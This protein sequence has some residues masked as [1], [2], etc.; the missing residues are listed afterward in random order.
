MFPVRLLRRLTAAFAGASL[1]LVAGAATAEPCCKTRNLITVIIDGARWEEVFRGIDPRFIDPSASAYYR[2][3]AQAETFKA[4]LWRETPQERREALAPFLWTTVAA[5][6][7]L[8][9]NHDKGSQVRLRNGFHISYPGHSEFLTGIADDE[10]IVSNAFKPNPNKTILEALDARLAFSGRVAAFSTWDAYP[11]ILDV[12]RSGLP[13][14][15]PATPTPVSDPEGR[16]DVLKGLL[17]DTGPSLHSDAITF[18]L[19]L[20]YLKL[21]RP[22]VLHLSFQ[23]ADR[24]AHA[25]HYDDYAYAI[26]SADA[27]LRQIWEWVQSDP[28]YRDQTT[29]IVATDHGRGAASLELFKTHGTPGYRRVAPGEVNPTDGDQYSWIAILGPD[30]PA[31]GEISG[32][33]P[34][35]IAQVAATAMALLREPYVG[36][37]PTLRPAPPIP[38][39]LPTGGWKSN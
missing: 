35:E 3:P 9:G 36:D 1:A 31:G 21:K 2:L 4:A 20:E 14:H 29:L 38:T 7:Q 30:T 18:R 19:A 33:P 32:G 26:R 6:G 34:I 5:R 25:G 8:Y 10:R 24:P 27:Y 28:D 12:A 17:T 16:M 15:S 11:Y 22:R 37:H 39:A 23:N 13:V